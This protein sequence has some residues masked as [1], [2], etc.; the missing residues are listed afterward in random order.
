M[1]TPKKLITQQTLTNL[2]Y[3]HN[4][5]S[6][7]LSSTINLSDKDPLHLS[8]SWLRFYFTNL[9]IYRLSCHLK[10]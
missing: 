2:N 3:K 9:T 4:E 6:N 1:V 7:P 10:F 8:I 5:N